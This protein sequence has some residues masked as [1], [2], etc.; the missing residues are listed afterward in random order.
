MELASQV[1]L[2]I[3][4]SVEERGGRGT[5]EAASGCAKSV[6][7]CGCGGGRK[8]QVF[9]VEGDVLPIRISDVVEV[10][11]WGRTNVPEMGGLKGAKAFVNASIAGSFVSFLGP[12]CR[13]Y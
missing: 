8:R 12:F 10:R 9:G 11:V 7:S 3:P 1:K 13:K 6:V 4:S 5:D 2:T